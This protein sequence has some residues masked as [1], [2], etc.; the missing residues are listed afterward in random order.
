MPIN[1]QDY[2]HCSSSWLTTPSLIV[3]FI[4]KITQ[5]LHFHSHSTLVKLQ[6]C[7]QSRTDKKGTLET[8]PCSFCL[9]CM[10]WYWSYPCHSCEN[11]TIIIWFDQYHHISSNKTTSSIL[12]QWLEISPIISLL[13]HLALIGHVHHVEIACSFSFCVWLL[14]FPVSGL[15]SSCPNLTAAY[16]FTRICVTRQVCTL[17][18]LKACTEKEI[19]QVSWEQWTLFI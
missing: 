2:C 14:M 1:Q 10:P 4:P 11:A 18:I 13:H 12:L 19:V 8:S 7:S 15:K 16:K 17:L 6:G 3:F 5:I 9:L